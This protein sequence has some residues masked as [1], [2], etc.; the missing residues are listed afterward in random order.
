MRVTFLQLGGKV[1][2]S[3]KKRKPNENPRYCTDRE[4]TLGVIG[5]PKEIEK[6]LD[7][8]VPFQQ[9]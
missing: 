2:P 8:L 6:F 9:I 1:R 3:M 4:D 5:G 7:W